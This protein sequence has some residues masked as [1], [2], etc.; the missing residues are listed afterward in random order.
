MTDILQPHNAIIVT[1]AEAMCFFFCVFLSNFFFVSLCLFLHV[2]FT[3]QALFSQAAV[4]RVAIFLTLK[5]TRLKNKMGVACKLGSTLQG[6]GTF[7]EIIAGTTSLVFY[8]S[9]ILPGSVKGMNAKK[10]QQ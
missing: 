4:R 5:C 2:Q 3:L 10:V 6:A 9:V 7:S 8:N 1:N